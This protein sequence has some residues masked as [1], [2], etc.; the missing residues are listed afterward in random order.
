[1]LK[2]YQDALDKSTADHLLD[3]P[4]IVS[5]LYITGNAPVFSTEEEGGTMLV[6]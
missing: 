5:S 3:A 1:M 2:L 6:Y 4:T